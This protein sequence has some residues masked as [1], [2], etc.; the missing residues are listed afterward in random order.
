MISKNT[1]VAV[2]LSTKFG[3]ISYIITDEF[4]P[5]SKF[6]RTQSFKRT[7]AIHRARTHILISKQFAR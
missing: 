3:T 1:K 6:E 5:L 7:A 2:I 4:G